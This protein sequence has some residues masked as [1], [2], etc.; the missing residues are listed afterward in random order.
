MWQTFGFEKSKQLF[1]RLIKPPAGENGLDHAYLFSGQEMIGKRTFALELAGR[2]NTA[3]VEVDTRVLSANEAG[4]DEVRALKQWLGLTPYAIEYKIAILDYAHLMR[5]EAATALLKILA[6]PPRYALLIL[7]S[8]QP[9]QLLPTIYSRCQT[10]RFLPHKHAVLV[11]YLQTIGLDQKQAEWFAAFSNGRVGLAINLKNSAGFGEIKKQLAQLNRL[12]SGPFQ[13][14]L[15]FA[16][17]LLGK[18][19]EV[20][21]LSQLLLFWILYLRSPLA[22]NLKTDRIKVLRNLLAARP[23][24]L[25]SQYNQRLIFENF[26]LSL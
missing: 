15:A 13:E 4:I 23:L 7:I 19:G 10:I 22:K 21:D 20:G 25:S 2:I 12:I 16:E 26:L 8:S 17:K 6:E 18:G 5:V 9:K 11:K 24:L 1:E 14:R 3:K